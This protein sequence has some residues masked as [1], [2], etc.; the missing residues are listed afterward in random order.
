MAVLRVRAVPEIPAVLGWRRP[1]T[2]ATTRVDLTGHLG[3]IGLTRTT[4]RSPCAA[5]PRDPTESERPSTPP[6]RSAVAWS[7]RPGPPST[8]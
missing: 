4:W 6:T 7:A 1:T 5:P 8:P 3:L 2:I